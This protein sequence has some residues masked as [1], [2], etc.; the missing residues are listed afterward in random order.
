MHRVPD[1]LRDLPSKELAMQLNLNHISYLPWYGI[2]RH[3]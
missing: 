2:G 1:P 3:R